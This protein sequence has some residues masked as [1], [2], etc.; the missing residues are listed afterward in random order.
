MEQFELLLDDIEVTESC[1]DLF[2][3]AWFDC[4]Q[5]FLSMGYTSPKMSSDLESIRGCYAANTI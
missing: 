3:Y 5:L 2:P 1:W 4:N